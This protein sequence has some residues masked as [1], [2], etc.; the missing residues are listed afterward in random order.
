MFST[1]QK[2]FAI[3]FSI[4]FIITMIYVYRRD[5]KQLKTQYKGVYWILLV[6]LTFIGLLFV[7]KFFL[8]E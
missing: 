1:G 3:L 2:Y 6:F 5:L 4:V 7:I 8:K